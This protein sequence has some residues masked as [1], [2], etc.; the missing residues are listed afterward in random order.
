MLSSPLNK[1]RAT[2][3][4]EPGKKLERD[5]M[6]YKQAKENMTPEQR[7]AAKVAQREQRKQRTPSQRA[8][9]NA[10]KKEWRSKQGSEKLNAQRRARRKKKKEEKEAETEMVEID[11]IGSDTSSGS[12]SEYSW[13]DVP[14]T[15]DN[16]TPVESR[17]ALGVENDAKKSE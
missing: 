9:D 13:E 15:K 5:N 3:T 12:D 11:G 10:R 1:P 17:C 8:R 7:E 14:L 2:H 4:H 6:K 16:E